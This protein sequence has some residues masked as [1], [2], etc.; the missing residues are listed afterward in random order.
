MT[1]LVSWSLCTEI[2]GW[3]PV[4]DALTFV[5]PCSHSICR[6]HAHS[7]TLDLTLS[8]SFSVILSHSVHSV[9]LCFTLFYSVSFGVPR[10][11]ILRA[12]IVLIFTSN[13]HFDR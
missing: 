5:G 10:I 9:L 3:G 13:I 4:S 2:V 6:R 12:A 11:T 1:S 8:V 7:V